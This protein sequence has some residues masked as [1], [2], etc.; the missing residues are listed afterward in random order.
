MNPTTLID[1]VLSGKSPTEVLE[2]FINEQVSG[3]ERSDLGPEDIASMVQS[4]IDTHANGVPYID[5]GYVDGVLNQLRAG[6]PFDEILTSV[7]RNRDQYAV[8]HNIGTPE[9]DTWDVI[10]RA[11]NSVA[12]DQLPG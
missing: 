10:H 3:P 2:S 4:A 11:L 8:T 6:A 5:Y 9:R 12:T 7:S 1:N